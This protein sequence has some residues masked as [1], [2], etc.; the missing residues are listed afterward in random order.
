MT[1][2]A[3]SLPAALVRRSAQGCNTN[4]SLEC[5][6]VGTQ[7]YLTSSDGSKAPELTKVGASG[8]KHVAT[9]TQQELA[10]DTAT[11]DTMPSI[12]TTASSS[13]DQSFFGRL[14]ALYNESSGE[15][16]LSLLKQHVTTA[17]RQFDD[18]VRTVQTARLALEKATTTYDDVN[19]RHSALMM[20]RDSWDSDDATAFATLTAEEVQARKA[21]ATARAALRGAEED[22][23]SR[24][25]DYIDAMRRR[26]HEEQMWQDRWRVV[27][28][29]G[30]WTPVSYTHLTLPTILRV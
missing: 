2:L 1:K 26:Y 23:S 4:P 7:R 25:V 24:Q 16:E 30:T 9:R 10:P 11:L 18:G 20:R 3:S 28:T 27:G 21:L 17:S 6:T 13:S 14:T 5:C 22:V 8:G 12:T 29:Y 19:K 15:N